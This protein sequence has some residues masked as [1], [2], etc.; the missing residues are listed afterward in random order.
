MSLCKG[1]TSLVFPI[2]CSAPLGFPDVAT[3]VYSRT[4]L[5]AI[6]SSRS[7]ASASVA[8]GKLTGSLRAGSSLPGSARRTDPPSSLPMEEGEDKRDGT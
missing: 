7:P 3:P 8:L 5:T 4:P 2:V 6:A 1:Q